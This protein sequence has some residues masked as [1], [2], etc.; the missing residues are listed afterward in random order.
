MFENKKLKQQVFELEVEVDRLK[1]IIREHNQ[2]MKTQGFD[3]MNGNDLGKYHYSWMTEKKLDALLEYLG[4]EF[5][6][7]QP[8]KYLIQKR[9]DKP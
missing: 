3:F 1:L 7:K 8:P 4:L 9:E 5:K 2:I 6:E